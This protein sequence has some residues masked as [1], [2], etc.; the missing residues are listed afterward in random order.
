MFSIGSRDEKYFDRFVDLMQQTSKEMIDKLDGLKTE[1]S[2]IK[3]EVAE[4][5][6]LGLSVGKI[7]GRIEKVEDTI[8]KLGSQII[9]EN[10]FQ[11]VVDRIDSL[12]KMISE[13]NVVINRV[14][15]DEEQREERSQAFKINGMVKI[16]DVVTWL[17]IAGA[18]YFVNNANKVQEI[19]S[20]DTISLVDIDR[21]GDR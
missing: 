6:S 9:S 11:K 15:K 17:L 1:V 14:K 8:D 20:Q 5:K 19:Q 4:L 13:I 21:Y 3:T 2:G 18:V 16:T 12:Q 10:E 7:E